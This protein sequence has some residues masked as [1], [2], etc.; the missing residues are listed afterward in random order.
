MQAILIMAHRD[1]EQIIE[2]TEIL[3]KKFE[4]YIH[5]DTKMNVS[6]EEKANLQQIGAHIYQQVNVNWGGWGIAEAAHILM[7]EAMK[8]PEITYV[9]VISGQCYPAEN[10][11]K[12]YDFY[13]KSTHNRRERPVYGYRGGSRGRLYYMITTFEE[14]PWD[15]RDPH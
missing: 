11:E 2:L 14:R 3:R 4:V 10:V 15:A 6:S 1:M 9:H 8:N 12:I 5:F 13:V 7:R